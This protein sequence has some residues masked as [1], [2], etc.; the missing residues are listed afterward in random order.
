MNLSRDAVTR[1]K[2]ALNLAGLHQDDRFDL[3]LTCP[4]NSVKELQACIL[5]RDVFFWCADFGRFA[6][7][8]VVYSEFACY[9]AVRIQDSSFLVTVAKSSVRSVAHRLLLTQRFEVG[10]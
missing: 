3:L 6:L 8:T 7:D 5:P 9:K 4:A 1:V 2:T 10:R